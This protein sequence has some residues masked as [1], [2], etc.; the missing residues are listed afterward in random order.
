MSL[1]NKLEIIMKKEINFFKKNLFK[2]E[3]IKKTLILLIILFIFVYGCLFSI[4]FYQASYNYKS[5]I[6]IEEKINHFLKKNKLK[7]LESFEY[8]NKFYKKI[9]I[10]GKIKIS[11]NNIL[12]QNG[13]VLLYKNNYQPKESIFLKAEKIY[14]ENYKKGNFIYG[15]KNVLIFDY[16]NNYIAESEKLIYDFSSNNI[17]LENFEFRFS[18]D[19]LVK[20]DNL[21]Y[22]Y[23]QKK[24]IL[25][26]NIIISLIINNEFYSYK[27]KYPFFNKFENIKLVGDKFILS[28]NKNL[29]I[30]SNSNS[31]LIFDSSFL[32][33][34]ELLFFIDKKN[35][36]IS[37]KKA[38]MKL[39]FGDNYFI[40]NSN[41]LKLI[42]FND[43]FKVKI[44][45]GNIEYLF[46]NNKVKYDNL[47]KFECNLNII[48]GEIKNIKKE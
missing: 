31:K 18:E 24:L 32:E 19:I 35:N 20:G 5:R 8:K 29:E 46:Q 40:S 39:L 23:L 30:Y 21:F 27:I 38:Y 17:F 11:K 25:E 22:I 15:I 44:N 42:N 34:E 33:S 13:Y 1:T 16:Q 12:L 6:N 7:D 48:N 47:N 26:K 3:K 43:Y 4:N 36:K 10:K 14:I 41:E 45:H 28:F 37:T 2:K 9:I